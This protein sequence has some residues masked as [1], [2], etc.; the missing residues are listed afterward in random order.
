MSRGFSIRGGQIE[1]THCCEGPG[2]KLYTYTIITTSSNSYLKFLHD[3]M[4]VILDPNT[5]AMRTWLDPSRTTW[6]KDLQSILKPYEGDLECYP[7][8]KEVGKVGNNSPEFIVPINSAENK[9]NI[10]NFFAN[11]KKEAPLKNEPASQDT[12][13]RRGVKRGIT[14]ETATAQE[15]GKKLRVEKTSKSPSPQKM[16]MRSATHN[17]P[18]KKKSSKGPT[19]GSQRIT[20]FFTQ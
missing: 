10:A 14:E 19:D 4:P 3:R 6:S 13:A 9:S 15:E 11:A 12:E 2:D 1:L 16:K 7:V 18:M 8:S 17:S 5:D 20:N